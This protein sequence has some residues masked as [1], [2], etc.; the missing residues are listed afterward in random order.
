M[1]EGIVRKFWMYIGEAFF[2][3]AGELMTEDA[4]VWLPNSREVFRGRDKF[5]KFNKKYPGRW[6]ISIEK[7]MS[8]GDTVISIIKV[9]AEDKSSSLY[10]TSVVIFKNNLINEM[11]EYWGDNGEPPAWRLKES[12]SERY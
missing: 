10:A 9:E 2:D 1:R 12:L 11:V 7:M 5:V 8:K 6:Y 4:I 3:N